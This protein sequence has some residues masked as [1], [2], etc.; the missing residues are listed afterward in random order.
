MSDNGIDTNS[1]LWRDLADPGCWMW[2]CVAI[3]G[4]AL[5]VIGAVRVVDWVVR[6]CG[7]R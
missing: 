2:G 3:I 4:V 6:L 5:V 7:G 1:E